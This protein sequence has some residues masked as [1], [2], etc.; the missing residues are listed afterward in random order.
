MKRRRARTAGAAAA[1]CLLAAAGIAGAAIGVGSKDFKVPSNEI[2][3]KTAEC[4]KGRA[5]SGGFLAPLPG[6]D[7]PVMLPLDS[8]MESETGWRL[9]ARNTGTSGKATAYVYCKRGAPILGTASAEDTIA[10]DEV[11]SIAAECPEGQEAVAGGFDTPDA[12]THLLA[13]KRTGERTWEVTLLQQQRRTPGLHRVR[14]LRCVAAW[15]GDE[16]QGDHHGWNPGALRA[17]GHGE[18]QALAGP[19]VRRLRDRARPDGPRRGAR[20]G[21]R[22]RL[23]AQ[24]RPRLARH[25]LRDRGQSGADGVRLLRL[26]LGGPVPVSFPIRSCRSATRCRS[27]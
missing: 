4:E 27:C 15:A 14:L 17:I 20:P 5:L 25:G 18:M 6:G 10:A 9:R 11:G 13:S 12:V 8:T 3:E 23:E 1:V 19:A 26:T 21:F 22:S 24:R 2:R 16:E 7:K